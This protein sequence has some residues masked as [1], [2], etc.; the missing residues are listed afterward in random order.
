[1]FGNKKLKEL[2]SKM[3]SSLSSEKPM[4]IEFSGDQELEQVSGY[5]NQLI[6][7][8]NQANLQASSAKDELSNQQ[9]L[10]SQLEDMELAISQLGAIGEM[11][12]KLASNLS[13]D[14]LLSDVF[15]L[16]ASNFTVKE[17]ELALLERWRS[18]KNLQYQ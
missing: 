6:N 15:N 13:L 16:I 5:F 14:V 7:D 17:I 11:G 18:S 4:R 2:L 12:K 3:E 8:L 9:S 10:S 1:M